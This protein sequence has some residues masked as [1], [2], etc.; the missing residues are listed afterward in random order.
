MAKKIASPLY[1]KNLDE[2]TLDKIQ[3]LAQRIVRARQ[4]VVFT[5]AGISTESGIPDYRSKGGTWDRFQPVYFD[6][7]MA[8]KKARIKYWDQ[9]LDMEKTLK[10]A[11][12]NKGHQSIARLHDLGCLTAVIT[13]NID[14]LHQESGIPSDKILEL[15]GNTRRV[16]CLSC[17][18]LISW[19]AVTALIAAGDRAPE[20]RCGGYLK[21][22]TISFGQ[23]MPQG[24][25]RQAAMISSQSKVFIVVGSTLL[26]HPA[27]LMPEYAKNGGAFLAIINLAPTPY[28]SMCSL[29]IQEPAGNVLEELA[30]QV[31][32]ALA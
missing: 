7:F 5:G 4:V 16:R 25:T 28:D 8:S 22:D 19:E 24:K 6:E 29:L 31:K 9:R 13:Q 20:C 17:K 26:V 14:G 12:P 3:E 32:K 1:N 23:A 15:H 11:R 18:T 27:A 21:P 10:H 2:K 30:A